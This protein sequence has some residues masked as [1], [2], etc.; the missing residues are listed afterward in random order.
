VVVNAN[1]EIVKNFYRV[2]V[3]ASSLWD[4]PTIVIPGTADYP[5]GMRS[6][7]TPNK[8]SK[9][10]GQWMGDFLRDETDPRYANLPEPERTVRALL[11]GRPLRGEVM[12][13]T[14]QLSSV[15]DS[16]LRKIITTFEPSK[17]V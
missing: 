17:I 13:I 9:Y 15:S 11:Q 7:L 8:L 16:I 10:E 12:Y 5:A 3:E 1:S 6:R 2:T 14:L 4:I